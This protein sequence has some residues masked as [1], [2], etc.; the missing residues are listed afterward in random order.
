MSFEELNNNQIEQV[1]AMATGE[2]QQ[3][4]LKECGVELDDDMLS[5]VAGGAGDFAKRGICANGGTH[6]LVKTGK[7]QRNQ[8]INPGIEFIEYRCTKCGKT[9]FWPN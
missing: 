4:Y 9:G 7:R 2:E 1:N 3:A 5:G 6:N 8:R